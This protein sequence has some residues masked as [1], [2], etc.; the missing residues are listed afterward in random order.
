MRVPV[1]CPHCSASFSATEP[2]ELPEADAYD[3]PNCALA[4]IVW[5]HPD[6]DARVSSMT[7]TE[8]AKA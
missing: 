4:F 8:Q 3:C 6:G 5:R 7:R 1:A 2:P